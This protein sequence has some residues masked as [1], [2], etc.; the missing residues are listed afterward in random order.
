[1][2]K[3]FIIKI[4]VFICFLIAFIW[5]LLPIFWL[6]IISLT[7]RPEVYSLYKNFF[8]KNPTFINYIRMFIPT[9]AW[10]APV[11]S[12]L[13]ISA[14]R[15]S[16]IASFTPAIL[17]LLIAS[18]AA[19]AIQK[20][21][22]PGRDKIT[23]FLL[24]LRALP[25]ATIAVPLYFIIMMF[26]LYDTLLGLILI[27]TTLLLPFAV[28]SLSEAFGTVPKDL[29][30]AAKIDGCGHLGVLFRVIIP[31]MAPN[32][33]ATSILV[34]ILSWNSFFIP[35]IMTQSA[36]AIQFT[37]VIGQAITETDVDYPLVAAGGIICCIIPVVLALVFQ[38]YLV[39]GL[40]S[41]AIKR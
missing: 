10:L 27:Y 21:N 16:I 39:K 2:F 31:I 22:I 9:Q 8:P 33:L 28:F 14:L 41:G 11:S 23:L 18:P 5:L 26:G 7:P 13:Y 32:M 6:T 19:Y 12:E 3:S 36:K 29:E 40:V 25:F 24:A 1:M 20:F 37:V 38:K 30:D 17:A 4:F 34:Y 35:I 15:N